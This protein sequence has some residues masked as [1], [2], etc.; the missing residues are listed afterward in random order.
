MLKTTLNS[1]KP[2]YKQN[3]INKEKYENLHIVLKG[4]FK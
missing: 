4:G 1:Q 2:I 3:F